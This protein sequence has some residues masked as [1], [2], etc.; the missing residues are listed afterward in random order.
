[1]LGLLLLTGLKM[2][3]CRDGFST[4][5]RMQHCW[6]LEAAPQICVYITSL[7]R[8]FGIGLCWKS[9]VYWCLK[10][11]CARSFLVIGNT[12]II[13]T[14][15]LWC[16]PRIHDIFHWYAAIQKHLTSDCGWQVP[17]IPVIAPEL[18]CVCIPIC[19]SVSVFFSAEFN[20][21]DSI[22]HIYLY[23]TA[24]KENKEIMNSNIEIC[25]VL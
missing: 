20:F 3:H 18:W 17:S 23:F 5:Q 21:T 2:H 7:I 16:W 10:E 15:L 9:K 6:I 13:I 11:V 24:R 19:R 1:M 12:S 14:I 4:K 22:L 25:S 8:S